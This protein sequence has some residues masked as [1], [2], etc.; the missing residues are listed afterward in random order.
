MSSHTGLNIL[1]KVDLTEI[2]SEVLDEFG[3]IKVVDA[4]IYKQFSQSHIS[5]LALKHGIYCLPT[6]E[7]IEWLRER[8]GDRK[9]IEVGAGCGIV[10]RS[11]GIKMTDNFQ[12]LIPKYRKA[13][14]AMQQPIVS[15]GSDVLKCDALSAVKRF[16]PEVV[17]G[18]WVTH[19]YNSKLHHLQ[20]NE[21]GINENKLVNRVQ[22]YIVVG[23]STVHNLKPI[24]KLPH[25]T[26]YQDWLFSRGASVGADCIYSWRRSEIKRS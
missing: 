13:Y 11:L 26:I 22:E 3:Q 24:M 8:I 18:C 7:L 2:E 25:E 21:L 14:E 9:A 20:G 1:T 5:Q 19:L 10:G 12:Q 23:N 15:Y 4:A 6:T 16:K 17:I